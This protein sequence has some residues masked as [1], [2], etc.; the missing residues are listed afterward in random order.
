MLEREVSAT[1]EEFRRGLALAFPGLVVATGD[2]LRV[3][4]G[5]VAMEISLTPGT[6]RVIAAITLSRLHVTIKFVRGTTSEQK[7]ML[8]RMDLAM[9]RGGG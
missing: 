3:D 9:Q 4:D 5:R 6:S 2:V 8:A 7:S 1:P